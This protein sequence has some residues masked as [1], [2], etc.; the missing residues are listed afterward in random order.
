M[1]EDDEEFL[2]E[3]F[4]RYDKVNFVSKYNELDKKDA[5]KLINDLEDQFASQP[6]PEPVVQQDNTVSK[7][8]VQQAPPAD[9]NFESTLI[10]SNTE[11]RF[12][13]EDLDLK[14]DSPAD[15]YDLAVL[16]Q[17]KVAKSTQLKY[18]ME[19]GLIVKTN[20]DEIR[21]LTNK[22][23]ERVSVKGGLEVHDSSDALMG[24]ASSDVETIS[25]ESGGRGAGGEEEVAVPD[26][27][28]A[29]GDDVRDLFG[30]MFDEM[31]MEKQGASIDALLKNT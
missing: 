26:G 8:D 28:K 15:F 17:A 16:D 13:I 23:Q 7:T 6:V 9:P 27:V 22:Y 2:F 30:E 31:D 25:V 5:K 14:F 20:Y 29:T 18:F 21:E 19:V 4:R 10:R 12:A 24:G 11:K 3:L 1:T